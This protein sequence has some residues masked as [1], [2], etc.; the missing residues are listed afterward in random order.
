MPTDL[1]PVQE[2]KPI[3]TRKPKM[4][5]EE[6]AAAKAAKDA[7]KADKP[8]KEKKVREHIPGKFGPYNNRTIVHL[9]PNAEAAGLRAGS[10]REAMLKMVYDATNTDE[11]LGKEITVEKGTYKIA[12]DNL[13]TMIKRGFINFTPQS[14]APPAEQPIAP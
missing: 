14:V 3:R 9:L 1:P 10:K 12:S 11:V 8:P 7:A 2:V 5:D 13:A 4:T 6:K